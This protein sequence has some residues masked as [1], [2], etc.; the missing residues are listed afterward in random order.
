MQMVCPLDAK[1]FRARRL[2]L[3]PE[4]FA[5][6][7]DEPDSPPT[8]LISEGPWNG[9]MTLPGDVA[10][11]TTSHQGTRVTILYELWSGWVDAMPHGGIVAEAMLYSADD[12][13]VDL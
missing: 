11:R 2:I 13:A 7:D 12:F 4:D 6:G 10:I 9:I 5:L 1:D 3:E 8:D